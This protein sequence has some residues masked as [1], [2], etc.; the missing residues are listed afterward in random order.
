MNVISQTS[1]REEN[2]VFE[3]V[4][5]LSLVGL[6]SYFALGGEVGLQHIT[7]EVNRSK[8][9]IFENNKTLL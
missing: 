7:K 8:S 5:L 9:A 2:S 4:V 6:V 3:R 1:L